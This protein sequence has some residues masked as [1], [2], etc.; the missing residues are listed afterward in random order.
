MAFGKR[1]RQINN[2]VIRFD[3]IYKY[4]VWSPYGVCLE[5]RLTLEEA[6]EY[7]N[8]TKDFISKG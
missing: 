1:I 2:L 5:D 4:C 8:N 6:V 3:E 7:C